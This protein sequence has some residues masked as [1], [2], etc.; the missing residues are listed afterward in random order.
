[1]NHRSGEIEV[2][3]AFYISRL[4]LGAI[5]HIEVTGVLAV[6]P[7]TSLEFL[8]KATKSTI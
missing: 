7:V 3:H 1:M 4:C 8:K 2:V 6:T 5:G